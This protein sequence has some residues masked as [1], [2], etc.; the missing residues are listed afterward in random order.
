VLREPVCR[1]TSP[2]STVRSRLN[3]TKVLFHCC[4]TKAKRFYTESTSGHYGDPPN[5]WR[6]REAYCGIGAASTADCSLPH[7]R[8]TGA[9]VTSRRSLRVSRTL[10]AKRGGPTE[11]PL[12]SS[13]WPTRIAFIGTSTVQHPRSRPT[14]A[15]VSL[16][17]GCI[18]W[19]ASGLHN[20]EASLSHNTRFA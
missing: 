16:R 2:E 5:Y 3:H 13:P 8:W 6:Y 10:A 14:Y 19:R 18:A 20:S 17:I 1:D 12:P 11:D 15:W 4:F 7:P 9:R